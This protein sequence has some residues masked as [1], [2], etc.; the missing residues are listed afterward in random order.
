MSDQ[1]YD[2]DAD[3]TG[4]ETEIAHAPASSGGSPA[5][6]AEAPQPTSGSVEQQPTQAETSYS[7]QDRSAA[8]QPPAPDNSD[9]S[10][11]TT[12]ETGYTRAEDGD[13]PGVPNT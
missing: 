13:G 5:D 12:A 11:P 6:R 9:P 7:E 3:D 8:P 1:P 4:P 2:V 10:K